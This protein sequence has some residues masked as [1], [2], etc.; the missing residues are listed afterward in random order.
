M[1]SMDFLQTAVLSL[2][3]GI[4]EF[5]PI[6]SSAHLILVPVITGWQDQGLAFDVAVHAGTLVAVVVY[7]RGRLTEMA[8]GLFRARFS[9]SDREAKLA[10]AIVLATL[11]VALAGVVFKEF[12]ETSLR[13]PSVI[14]AS[15]IVFALV[16]WWSDRFSSKHRDEYSITW[17]DALIIGV[18]QAIALV[19]GTSRAGITMTAAL[20]L[21]LNRTAAARF[22]FLLSIPTLFA[23][24]VFVTG[25][26]AASAEPVEWSVL[27]TGF[28]LSA[29]SAYL[30]MH[31]FI[32]LVDRIGMLPFVIYRLAL[33]A[34]LLL[35][36]T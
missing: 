1:K 21:G 26:L 10:W 11:P 5:L 9:T 31:F 35:I 16:L 2:V 18:A 22:S 4:T 15:T 30:S 32:R 29:I 12:I 3:Q 20:F 24:G 34:L 7:F 27:L 19:P 23:A 28:A 25:D 17:K 6:S 36:V 13:L 8:T 33:G 14:A